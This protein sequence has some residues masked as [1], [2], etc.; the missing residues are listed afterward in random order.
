ML[1]CLF[2]LVLPG[3]GSFTLRRMALSGAD[4]GE[5]AGRGSLICFFSE[6]VPRRL[7]LTCFDCLF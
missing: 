2:C 7:S 6:N 4:R 3:E 1:R 5:L